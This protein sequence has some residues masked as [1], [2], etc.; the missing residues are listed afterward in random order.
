MA[1]RIAKGTYMARAS[2]APRLTNHGE[3]QT[4][5]VSATM[6]ITEETSPE[7]G[8]YLP[9]NGWLTT[10]NAKKR[11]A[12]A[13]YAMGWDGDPS[14]FDSAQTKSVYIVVD[15]EEYNGETKS[16]IKFINDPDRPRSSAQT[17]DAGQQQAAMS[18]LRGLVLSMREE[19]AKRGGPTSPA[20][21]KGDSFDFG[22]NAPPAAGSKSP[23]AKA[24]F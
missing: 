22:A 19:R 1:I 13:L 16:V 3:K 9:W 2:G 15:D 20:P 8:T 17:M 23:N 6:L 10:D 14:S 5:A 21:S 18:E 4:P 7:K 24:G 12:E 11:T